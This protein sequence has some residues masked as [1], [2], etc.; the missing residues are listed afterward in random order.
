M[1]LHSVP[2]PPSHQ[3]QRQWCHR[4]PSPRRDMVFLWGLSA[5]RL[6]VVV[7][8]LTLPKAPVALLLPFLKIYFVEV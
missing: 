3:W 7:S 2:M 1:Q 4:Y 8:A 6:K 5:L